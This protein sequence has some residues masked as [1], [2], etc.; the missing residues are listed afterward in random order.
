MSSGTNLWMAYI[1]FWF[2]LIQPLAPR[3]TLAPDTVAVVMN[4]LSG[5]LSLLFGLGALRKVIDYVIG[6]FVTIDN[7][8]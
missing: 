5:P 2:S 1:A 6:R 4:F 3:F 7:S 8:L